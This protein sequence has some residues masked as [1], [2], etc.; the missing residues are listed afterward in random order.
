MRCSTVLV[1]GLLVGACG[2]DYLLAPPPA[3]PGLADRQ[4]WCVVEAVIAADCLGCHGASAL[5]GLDL[6]ADAHAALV[7]APSATVPGATLVV[8]GDPAASFLSAKLRAD[9]QPGEGGS[10]PPGAPLSAALLDAVDAWISDG[11]PAT[12]DDAPPDAPQGVHPDGYALPTAH[13]AEARLQTLPCTSCHGPTLDGAAGP[14]CD[15]CHATAPGAPPGTAPDAWRTDCTFCHGDPA[16]GT[17]APPAPAVRPLPLPFNAHGAHVFDTDWHVAFPCET[18][19]LTPTSV[20]S[21]GH[22]FVGD[23]TPGAP[24]VTLA[25]LAGAGSWT[26][27]GTC[28]N[29]CHG[30]GLR[31]GPVHDGDPID[32][33]AS[34]HPDATSGRD[35]WD[36]MSGEHERHL[37]EGLSCASCHPDTTTDGRHIAA[38]ALHVDGVAQVQLPQG[39]TRSG[40]TCSGTCHGE[41]H[42]GRRWR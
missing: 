35:A 21:P 42:S 1:G 41:G 28:T 15:T 33:C 27:D 22:L 31:L 40:A 30:G 24:E 26:V 4:G 19:H 13:G 14:S 29:R 2:D 38:P 16:D 34:C 10:M 39:M 17:G 6:S 9:L 18:C 32:T 11:A 37:R 20:L 5:G 7:G 3:D 23:D 12:C 25:G 36:R 8:P